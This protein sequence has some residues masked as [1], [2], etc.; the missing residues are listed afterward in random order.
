MTAQQRILKRLKRAKTIY[1]KRELRAWRSKTEW[2]R[3][4]R[5]AMRGLELTTAIQ[6]LERAPHVASVIA[7]RVRL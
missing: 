6:L 1:R 2:A 7:G 4:Q 3:A 5:F